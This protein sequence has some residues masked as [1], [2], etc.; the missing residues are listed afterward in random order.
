MAAGPGG[1]ETLSTQSV[2]EAGGEQTD[3]DSSSHGV[4]EDHNAV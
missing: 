1:A 4:D 3:A 2:M